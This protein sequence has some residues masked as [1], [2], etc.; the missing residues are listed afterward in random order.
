M[1]DPEKLNIESGE[2]KKQREKLVIVDI[3]SCFK[4]RGY[5]EIN[6]VL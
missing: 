2:G 6:M 1:E 4:Y 5:V 3:F